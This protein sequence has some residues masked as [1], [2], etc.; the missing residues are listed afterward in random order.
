MNIKTYKDKIV[1]TLIEGGIVSHEESLEINSYLDN[2]GDY[3]A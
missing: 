2:F 3:D 1:P